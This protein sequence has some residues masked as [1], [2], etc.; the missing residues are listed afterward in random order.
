LHSLIFS[1]RLEPAA[2]N[3]LEMSEEVLSTAIRGDEPEALAFVEPFH[4]T[5]FSRHI[6]FLSKL[7]GATAH[8]A[9]RRQ[10]DLQKGIRLDR[11]QNVG[12]GRKT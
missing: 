1:Q 3:F 4:G 5:G 7:P 9:K 11:R 2:L 8:P 12:A 6:E 10:E